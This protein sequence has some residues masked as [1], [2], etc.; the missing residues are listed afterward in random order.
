MKF[1]NDVFCTAIDPPK[2]VTAEVCR[3]IKCPNTCACADYNQMYACEQYSSLSKLYDS[4]AGEL[5][6]DYLFADEFIAYHAPSVR[7]AR[8]FRRML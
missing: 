1:P 4:Y 2:W 6:D 3:S 5:D 7:P 8:C